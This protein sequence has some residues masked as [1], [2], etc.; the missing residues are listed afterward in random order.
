MI[1]ACD[2]TH[3]SLACLSHKHSVYLS[4]M[5]MT[6]LWSPNQSPQLLNPGKVVLYFGCP[7]LPSLFRGSSVVCHRCRRPSCWRRRYS[8][9]FRRDYVVALL[10]TLRSQIAVSTR[11]MIYYGR[12]DQVRETANLC[13]TSFVEIFTAVDSDQRVINCLPQISRNRS[14]KNQSSLC[15]T[16]GMSSSSSRSEQ[17]SNHLLQDHMSMLT[18]RDVSRRVHTC[19][20]PALNP[21]KCCPFC[22]YDSDAKDKS[23]VLDARNAFVKARVGQKKLQSQYFDHLLSMFMLA[24]SDREDFDG[25]ASGEEDSTSSRGSVVGGKSGSSRSNQSRPLSSFGSFV[26][27]RRPS[28]EDAPS[29]EDTDEEATLMHCWCQR[30]SYSEMVACAN[31]YCKYVRFHLDC[32]NN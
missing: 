15:Q 14:P 2:V 21:F 29:D 8:R 24:L 11:L 7:A 32:L 10:K 16:C 22:D 23:I 1:C 27:E 13:R 28:D 30:E 6:S 18:T 5:L 31:E 25:D 26:G 12:D 4:K 17:Y 20:A 9:S 3:L 19:G